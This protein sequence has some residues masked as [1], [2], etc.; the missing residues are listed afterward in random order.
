MKKK[1][2]TIAEI[3]AKKHAAESEILKAINPILDQLND[4]I[5]LPIKSIEIEIIDASTYAKKRT[6][7][8]PIIKLHYEP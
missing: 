5:E 6:L 4:E 7:F 1:S 2:L 8:N 3:H